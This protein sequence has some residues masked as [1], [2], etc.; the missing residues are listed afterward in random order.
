MRRSDF[1]ISPSQFFFSKCD[2]EGRI[3]KIQIRRRLNLTVFYHLA[4]KAH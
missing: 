3:S 2:E 1:K 4:V